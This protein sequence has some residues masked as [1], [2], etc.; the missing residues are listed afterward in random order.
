MSVNNIDSLRVPGHLEARASLLSQVRQ[1]FSQRKVLEVETP[2]ARS[3]TVTEPHQQSF[4]LAGPEG[5]LLVDSLFLQTSPEYA[6][7]QLLARGSGDI[8]QVCKAFRFGEQGLQHSP[9]FTMLEWYR[10]GFDHHRLMDELAELMQQLVGPKPIQ[11]LTWRDAFIRYAD[12]DPVIASCDQLINRAANS[13][14]T[15]PVTNQA[16]LRR[17]ACDLLLVDQVEPALGRDCLTFLYD[18]PAD[19][20]ALARVS[21]D[22]WPVAH[23]F[24]LY[25]EG[26]E[27]ANGF[28]EL[29]DA[30]EQRRRFQQDNHQRRLNGVVEVALD[31][32][33]LAVLDQLP[34][35][36][37]VAVGVDRVLQLMVGV[38]SLAEVKV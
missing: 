22:P 35:C 38:S 24:E 15:Q 29:A 4:Q 36:A 5:E 7:K 16:Q 3:Y 6:M 34:D 14:A 11:K 20:A 25:V 32:S 21:D 17:L 13:L 2:L 12:I 27:L 8:Y 19:Q 26:V 30:N 28:H 33:L 10:L 18:Y 23:R 9:E 31:E 37:G 1:F